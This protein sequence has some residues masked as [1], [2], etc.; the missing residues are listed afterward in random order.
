MSV[1]R[2]YMQTLTKLVEM[3]WRQLTADEVRGILRERIGD[4]VA[5]WCRD[6]DFSR[7][8]VYKVLSGDAEPTVK[9]CE[10]IGVSREMIF[11]IER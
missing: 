3:A 2:V 7:A 4:N 1:K 6:N 8:F 10:A 11:W 5:E 9:L